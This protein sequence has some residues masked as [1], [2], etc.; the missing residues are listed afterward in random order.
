M[1][2]QRTSA[3]AAVRVDRA[4]RAALDHVGDR[5]DD[6]HGRRIGTAA[7]VL[8]DREDGSGRWLLVAANRG[9]YVAVP[10]EGVLYG[11]GR[12]FCPHEH[13]QV[14]RG[15][16][17]KAVEAL[18]ARTERLL[19]AIFDVRPSRG[20]A[21]A[22]WERRRVTSLLADDGDGVRLDPPPRGDRGRFVATR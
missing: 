14:M 3:P 18:T 21:R 16:R 9:S 8:V 11:G 4:T 1:A 15:P 17:L 6:V 20:A 7:G 19:C 10:L 22:D 5:V 13:A 12:A 2:D